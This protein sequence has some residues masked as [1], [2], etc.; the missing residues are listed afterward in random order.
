MAKKT[1]RE[2]RSRGG[3]DD[4]KPSP[5]KEERKSV[6]PQASP[7]QRLQ[8]SIGGI[9]AALIEKAVIDL[10]EQVLNLHKSNQDKEQSLASIALKGQDKE[11]LG[12]FSHLSTYLPFILHSC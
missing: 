9:D 3:L 12:R 4:L 6:R 11:K 8:G 1:T 5:R 7:H 2:G 10:R